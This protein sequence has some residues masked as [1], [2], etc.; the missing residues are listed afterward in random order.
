MGILKWYSI[1]MLGLAVLFDV[2][3]L[4]FSI[5]NEYRF[6]NLLSAIVH[7]PIFI[8]LLLI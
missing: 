2:I 8:Y 5:N 1:I 7:I 3:G 6:K 4:F